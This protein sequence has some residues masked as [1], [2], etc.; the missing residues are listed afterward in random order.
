MPYSSTFDV[1]HGILL[2]MFADMNVSKCFW[3]WTRSFLE[4]R[5]QQVNLGG[6]LSSTMP[7]PLGVPQGSVLSLTLF[8]VHVND[9]ED[10]IPDHLTIN[11]YKYAYD[12]TQDE[13]IPSGSSSHMQEV[14]D[15]MNGWADRN[16]KWS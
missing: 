9:F 5:S 13:A 16:K 4:G 8:N 3:L 12:C 10:S 2:R 15:A 7:C 6:T 14:L 1:N 11:I